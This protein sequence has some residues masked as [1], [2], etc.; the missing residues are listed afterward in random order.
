MKAAVLEA[1]NH[2]EIGGYGGVMEKYIAVEDKD[3]DELRK[4]NEVMRSE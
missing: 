4:M 1:H 2:G 3:F